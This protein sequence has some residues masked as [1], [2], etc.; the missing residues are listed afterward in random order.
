[1]EQTEIDKIVADFWDNNTDESYFGESYWLANPIIHRRYNGKAAGGRKYDSWV[2]FTVDHYLKSGRNKGKIL[3]IGSGD[4][5][6]ERHLA[7]IQAAEKIHGIDLSPKRIDI[8]QKAAVDAGLQGTIMY[9]VGNV[10]TMPFPDLNYD[11]IY[12]NASLHHMSDL[13]QI[14]Q[15]CSRALRK[16]GF[17]FVNE[18]IGPNR[19]DF[20]RREKEVMT[21]AFHLIPE[22]YRLSQT[23]EEKGKVK[24][25]LM[26]PSPAEV[27]R[28]D[29]SEAIHSEEIFEAIEKNFEILEFNS[30]GGSVCQFM[31]DG[32]AGN[33]RHNDPESL[34]VLRL[35]FDIEDTLE[36][37]SDLRPHF[38]MFVACKR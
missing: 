9:F 23:G 22:K 36:A 24:T 32:I 10:E 26:F 29:P 21:A 3:S 11:A 8:A 15:S 1:M 27:A 37:L 2:N 33:F 28:V 4:G 38:G 13:T 12:F 35:I 34:K 18:Y 5:V 31:L 19:F 7:S 6:L 25:E 14:L 20:S 30:A 16:D 17:L